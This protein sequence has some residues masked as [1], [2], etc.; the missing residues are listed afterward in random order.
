M[1][2]G[3]TILINPAPR[4]ASAGVGAWVRRDDHARFR[5]EL[6]L[7]VDRPVIMS[8]H[9]AA[10]WH[11]GILAKMLAAGLWAER[12]G[13]SPAWLV[14]DQ[15]AN[16][17]T[18]VRVPVRDAKAP[19]GVSA[20]TWTFTPP[21]LLALE[22]AQ[23]PT[24]LI[25][26]FDPV[27]PDETMVEQAAL[28]SVREGLGRVLAA[29]RAAREARSAG[30]QIARATMALASEVDARCAMAM[31][32]ASRLAQTGLFAELVD[33]ML[34][35]PERCAWAYNAAVAAHPRA[36]VAPLAVRAGAGKI[37]L[38]LWRLDRHARTR[39]RV[40]NASLAG[41]ARADLAPRALL[42][43]AMLRL[44]G[45]ELFIHGLGGAGDD[46]QSGY[47]AITEQWIGQWLGRTLAPMVTVSATLLLPLRDQPPTDAAAWRRSAWSAHHARHSP[48]MLAECGAELQ[49]RALASLAADRRR[50]R[51]ERAALFARQQALLAEVRGAHG[52]RL[53]SMRAQAQAV[54]A[55]ARDEA[56]LADRTWAFPL[57]DALAL[58][59]LRDRLAEGLA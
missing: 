55:R 16:A 53:E 42:Q 28:G 4:A 41:V 10:V 3:A 36:G 20:A 56:L 19:A 33:A 45:C 58:R 51:H 31:V 7:P 15:D 47:D 12:T 27:A 37:E 13:A 23:T 38:P 24:G 52:A 26:A 1:N 30:E 43:T 6:G 11:P 49:K 9:Q 25:D 40:D 18:G 21:A 22:E 57:H 59:A 17:F 50:N 29:L 8:G 54:R 35:D 44:A 39:T 2:A 32:P 14:V 34:S 46:G 5:R 48:A